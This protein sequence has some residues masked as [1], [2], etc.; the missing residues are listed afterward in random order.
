M[1]SGI[2][3]YQSLLSPF[4][5]FL[6][7]NQRRGVAPCAAPKLHQWQW[8]N[9][10]LSKGVKARKQSA[11]PGGG[12]PHGREMFWKF[13]YQN[14]IFF[15]RLN[16][17]IR[18]RICSGN[19]LLIFV[20]LSDQWGGGAWPLCSSL[21]TPVDFPNLRHHSLPHTGMNQCCCVVVISLSL[22]LLVHVSVVVVVVFVCAVVWC[23]FPFFLSFFLSFYAI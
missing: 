15:C 2:L 8:C 14:G 9:H 1:W 5:F 10:D 23:S 11:R 12:V 16:A 3:V 22:L 18:G 13:V 20:L 6:L 4:Y 21:A 17:I 19:S 7:F